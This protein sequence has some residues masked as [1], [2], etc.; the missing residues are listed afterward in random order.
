[1]ENILSSLADV[2]GNII[3]DINQK[4]LVLNN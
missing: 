3:V 2:Y 1:M 4:T